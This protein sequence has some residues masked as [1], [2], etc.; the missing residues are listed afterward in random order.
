MDISE[1][2]L[3]TKCRE[4]KTANLFY[5]RKPR[6]KSP[7]AHSWCIV[8]CKAEYQRRK[9]AQSLWSKQPHRREISRTLSLRYAYLYPAR[10]MWSAA[11]QRAKSKRL[12]FNLSLEDIVIPS[13][14]PV[15]GMPLVSKRGRGRVTGN[16]PALDRMDSTKGYVKGNV[17]VIS[18]RA[19]AMKSNGTLE[20][21]ERIASY[22]RGIA[23][24]PANSLDSSGL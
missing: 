8:C 1:T 9:Q 10:R 15:L 7:R 22:M 11:K 20:E 13:H 5:R 21:I 14:C 19:N 12:D 16:S 24:L 6:S 4:T 3:C 17:R 18:F 2:K 23:S